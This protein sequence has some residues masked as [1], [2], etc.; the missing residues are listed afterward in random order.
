M[1]M[2]FNDYLPGIFD[3]EREMLATNYSMMLGIF[4]HMI[5]FSGLMANEKEEEQSHGYEFMRSLPIESWQ[6]VAGK[7]L[8]AI[9][10]ALYAIVLI[11]L[12]TNVS[13]VMKD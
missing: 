7:Y 2:L 3:E 6:I 1:A 9:C 13:L 12:V 10:Y 4:V 11:V 8:A 5:I